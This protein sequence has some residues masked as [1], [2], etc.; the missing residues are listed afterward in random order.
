MTFNVRVFYDTYGH[1]DRRS[2]NYRIVPKHNNILFNYFSNKRY[3]YV[4]VFVLH[5][6]CKM[7]VGS[8]KRNVINSWKKTCSVS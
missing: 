1:V 4:V 3:S 7:Y 8:T 2:R 6:M 5:N